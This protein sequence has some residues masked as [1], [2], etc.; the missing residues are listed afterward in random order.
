MN[1]RLENTKYCSVV[2][3]VSENAEEDEVPR[4]LQP[5]DDAAL[6]PKASVK[7]KIAL[8]I[9]VAAVIVTVLW[10]LFLCIV[11]ARFVWSFF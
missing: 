2:H 4:P 7:H 1:A 8:V 9:V 6:P 5:N 11:L 10:G 3:N